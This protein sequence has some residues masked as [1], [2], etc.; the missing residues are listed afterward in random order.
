MSKAQ[1]REALEIEGF[2]A[3]GM[4]EEAL[5]CARKALRRKS[6]HVDTFKAALGAITRYAK[7]AESWAKLIESAYQRLPQRKRA[8]ARFHM[9]DFRSD[10]SNYRGVLGL[11]PKRFAGDFALVELACA[12]DAAFKLGRNEARKRLA[13]RL[14]EAIGKAAHPFMRS[15][16]RFCFAESLARDGKWANAITVLEKAEG[17]QDRGDA[18]LGIARIHAVLGLIALRR[19][20]QASEQPNRVRNPAIREDDYARESEALMDKV[21]RLQGILKRIVPGEWRKESGIE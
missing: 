11:A 8:A 12:M 1:N 20:L 15:Q 17:R 9:M 4:G 7:R 13:K 5:L 19:W 6:I 10:C 14:P 16:L 2:E 21:K 3:L 18:A